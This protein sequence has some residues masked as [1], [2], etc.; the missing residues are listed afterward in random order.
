MLYDN[1][2]K[3]HILVCTAQREVLAACTCHRMIQV[4]EYTSLAISSQDK[5]AVGKTLCMCTRKSHT[6]GIGQIRH[7]AGVV[8]GDNVH[9]HAC[10]STS[11]QK[12]FGSSHASSGVISRFE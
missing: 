12:K 9:E 4:Q 2:I 3:G 10:E 1:C 8:L 7:I 6:N 11:S 5:F